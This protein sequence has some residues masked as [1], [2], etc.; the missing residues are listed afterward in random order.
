MICKISET[1]IIQCATELR[2]RHRACARKK[3]TSQRDSESFFSKFH[4]GKLSTLS[5]LNKPRKLNA[6]HKLNKTS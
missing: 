4:L 2:I 6:S 5:K 3:K 1:N